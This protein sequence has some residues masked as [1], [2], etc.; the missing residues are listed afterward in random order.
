MRD[1]RDCRQMIE[2]SHVLDADELRPRHDAPKV[3]SG[4]RAMA[5]QSPFSSRP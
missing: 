4:Y 2:W 5:T 3:R 1:L